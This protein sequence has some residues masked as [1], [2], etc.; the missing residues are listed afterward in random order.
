MSLGINVATLVTFGAVSWLLMGAYIVSMVFI[1]FICPFW[2]K[3]LQP[4][5]VSVIR[6]SSARPDQCTYSLTRNLR[7]GIQGPW[8][9]DTE[10]EMSS[11]DN[12]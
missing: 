6:T 9:Y 1:T 7:S 3:L 5:K 11:A 8:D 4:S 10:K 2:F 12:L